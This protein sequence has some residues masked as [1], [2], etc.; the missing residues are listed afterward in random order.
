VPAA[1]RYG[2][3]LVSHRGLY[4]DGVL[5]RHTRALASLAAESASAL[6]VNPGDLERLG[7][8]DGDQV[9]VSSS[10]T[11]LTLTARGSDRV[12]RGTAF[13]AFAQAGPGAAD[14][15]DGAAPV[16]DVRVETL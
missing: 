3:R 15:I 10:R 14:L 8:A 4:D 6:A 12:P 7:I 2:L 13:L 1:D 5:L 16:T 11:A 9:R